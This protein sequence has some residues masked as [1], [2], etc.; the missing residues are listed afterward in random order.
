MRPAWYSYASFLN[1]TAIDNT[2]PALP[3]AQM[4]VETVLQ[5]EYVFAHQPF[6]FRIDFGADRKD[7]STFG[8]QDGILRYELVAR[9]ASDI[10]TRTAIFGR[11]SLNV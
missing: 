6:L 10:S 11:A 9:P 5:L 8:T 2:Y 7:M 3:I 4:P 1:P